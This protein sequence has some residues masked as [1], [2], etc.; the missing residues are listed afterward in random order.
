[1]IGVEKV[2]SRNTL[3]PIKRI[4]NENGQLITNKQQI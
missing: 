4:S 2:S 1:M 3:R